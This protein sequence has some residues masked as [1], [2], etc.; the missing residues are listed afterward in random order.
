MTNKPLSIFVVGVSLTLPWGTA[1]ESQPYSRTAYP[2]SSASSVNKSASSDEKRSEKPSSGNVSSSTQEGQ[3]ISGVKDA[4][5]K[6]SEGPRGMTNFLSPS[7]S[8]FELADTSSPGSRRGAA[9]ELLSTVEGG[10][11]LMRSAHRSSFFTEYRGGGSFYK[12]QSSLNGS[13]HR[14]AVEEMVSFRNASLL[15]ADEVSYLQQSSFGFG[16]FIGGGFLDNSLFLG[17]DGNLLGLNPNLGPNQ[18]IL[19]N[20]PRL[21]NTSIAQITYHMNSRRSLTAAAGYGFMKA[22]E[23]R[24]F[25]DSN[26]TYFSLG[27]DQTLTARDTIGLSSNVVFF[28]FP[29]FNEAIRSHFIGLNYGRQIT[30]RLSLALSAGPQIAIVKTGPHSD[31]LLPYSASG[32][33]SYRFARTQLDLSAWRS[34]TGGG[35]VF[36]GADTDSVQVAL[37]RPIS[38]LWSGSMNLGYSRN[39]TLT[40]G[41]PFGSIGKGKSSNFSQ[42]AKARYDAKFVGFSLSRPFTHYGN[43][44][45]SYNMQQ[46]NFYGVRHLFGIGFQW[47]FRPIRIR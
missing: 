7:F 9:P 15:I 27:Y 11:T 39:T 18:S 22:F 44:S 33:M 30:G 8:F 23:E 3:P 12:D 38:R 16:N 28:R 6:S 43:L 25:I 1:Q 36:L 2:G 17:P 14:F 4:G 35:G 19:S 42:G 46:Q 31:T 20:I 29:I 26:Q 37:S 5:L 32:S 47:N 21:S 40:T 34:I 10:L 24:N 13:F 45:L 41:T